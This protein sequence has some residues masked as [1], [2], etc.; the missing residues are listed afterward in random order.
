MELTQSCSNRQGPPDGHLLPSH[1]DVT[2]RNSA[3]PRGQQAAENSKWCFKEQNP[4]SRS[5]IIQTV[6]LAKVIELPRMFFHDVETY[7]GESC[8]SQ[9]G[10]AD[11]IEPQPG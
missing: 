3:R 1:I 6:G 11:E 5:R 10:E 7:L 8:P 4:E 9:S 2:D